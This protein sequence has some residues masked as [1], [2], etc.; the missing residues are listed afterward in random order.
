VDQKPPEELEAP[1]MASLSDDDIGNVL[2]DKAS[3]SPE[4]RSE[5]DRAEE[6]NG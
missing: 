4:V 5:E 3:S 1:E 2:P 6:F